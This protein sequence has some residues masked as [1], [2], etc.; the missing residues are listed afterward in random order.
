M[1]KEFIVYRSKFEEHFA[2]VLNKLDVAYEYEEETLEYIVPVSTHKY[3]PDFVIETESGKKIYIEVKGRLEVADKKKMLLVREQHPEKD[4]RFVF[5]NAKGRNKGQKKTFG[6]WAD[7]N[8]FKYGH[9]T[10]PREWLK[11]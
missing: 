7:R 8:Q 1:I 9:K 11:E 5:Q 10:I 6:D 4:I 3:I 2:N